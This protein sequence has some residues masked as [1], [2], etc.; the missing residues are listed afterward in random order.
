LTDPPIPDI[1]AFPA[2]RRG[3]FAGVLAFGMGAAAFGQFAIGALAPWIISDL[4]L[5]RTEYG[6]STGVLF[7]V[8]AVSAPLLGR[9]VDAIG[10]RWTLALLFASAAASAGLLGRAGSH[11]VFLLAAGVGGVPMALGNAATND[12]V[13]RHVRP[14]QQGT[15][16]GIKQAGPQMAAVVIGLLV[17]GAALLIGWRNVLVC[18]ALVLSLGVVLV[19][20]AVPAASARAEDSQRSLGRTTDPRAVRWLTAYAFVMGLGLASVFAYLP[21][22]AFEALGYPENV[23]AMTSLALGGAGLAAVIVWGRV[24]EVRATS[25][26]PLTLLSFGAALAMV[27]LAAAAQLAPELVWIGTIAV[28]ATAMPW[29]VVAMF[30]VIRHVAR[31]RAGQATGI[32]LFAFYSGLMLSPIG[33]GLLLDLLN[34][35]TVAWGAVGVAFS[36]SGLVAGAWYLSDR[37]LRRSR[38]A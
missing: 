33:F 21:L 34:D 20:V 29:H 1:S 38:P 36:L 31:D 7:A 26:G 12:L 18:A 6:L 14:G 8:G 17:P 24:A 15:I 10:G 28:A 27:P 25:S 23:A 5:S 22:Y 9:L 35:Y 4:A 37:T 16:M 11:L 3:A 13:V 30:A 2:I 19:L 32:V